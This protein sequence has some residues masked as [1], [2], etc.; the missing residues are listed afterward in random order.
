MNEHKKAGTLGTTMLT[1][2]SDKFD[3]QNQG[4]YMGGG[5]HTAFHPSVIKKNPFIANQNMTGKQPKPMN[6]PAPGPRIL[7]NTALG[8]MYG[9]TEAGDM[10]LIAQESRTLNTSSVSN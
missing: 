4:A 9:Y 7:F 3:W 6:I 10:V 2:G 5:Y 8:L 1:K